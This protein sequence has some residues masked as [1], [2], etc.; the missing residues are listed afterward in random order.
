MDEMCELNIGKN[1]GIIWHLLSVEGQLNI[2]KIGEFTG[3][4]DSTIILALG[5]LARENK[6]E[7]TNQNDLL[8]FRLTAVFSEIY[9]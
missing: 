8:N 1:A 2:R 3:L 6:V 5:W 9:Y 7:I 4:R